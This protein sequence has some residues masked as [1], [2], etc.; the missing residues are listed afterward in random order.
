MLLLLL[1]LLLKL[2]FLDTAQLG[3]A[4]GPGLADG[5]KQSGPAAGGVNHLL[6]GSLNRGC[7]EK[8][9]ERL[10]ITGQEGC[11]AS[12]WALPQEP[13][14]PKRTWISADNELRG[15]GPRRLSSLS[16]PVLATLWG[17]RPDSL[18]L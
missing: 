16:N 5:L 18:V 2:A 6:R 7:E 15:R 13:D 3:L 14:T 1:F 10:S 8:G 17:D 4:D 9:E 12:G 11:P